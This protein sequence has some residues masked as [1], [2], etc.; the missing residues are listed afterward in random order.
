MRV[1]ARKRR[2][3]WRRK[4]YSH[5]ACCLERCVA[6]I[7]FVKISVPKNLPKKP[8]KT[9]VPTKKRESWR[10]KFLKPLPSLLQTLR[11]A[12]TWEKNSSPKIPRKN[13][14]EPKF[15]L[16][17]ANPGEE[18]FY[19]HCPCCFVR[20]VAPMLCKNFLAEQFTEKTLQDQ[21]SH[22]ETRILRK[23]IFTTIALAALHVAWRLCFVKISFPRTRV[24]RSGRE[25]KT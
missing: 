9:K 19:S 2:E 10:R 4:F 6:P 18:N 15:R 14:A 12:Y 16:R 5:R 3:S 23:K 8:C 11:S 22:E 13:L 25:P 17:A 7:C 20:C 1:S 24:Q 21:S